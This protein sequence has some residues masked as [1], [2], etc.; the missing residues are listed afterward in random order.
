[1]PWIVADDVGIL[2]YHLCTALRTATTMHVAEI[3]RDAGPKVAF[4]SAP[5]RS[6]H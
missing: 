2:K 1:M 5:L 4:C 3:L 6:Y